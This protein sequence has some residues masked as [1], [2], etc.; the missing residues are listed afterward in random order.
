MF[1]T[2]LLTSQVVLIQSLQPKGREF[3]SGDFTFYNLWEP[4]KDNDAIQCLK[5][6]MYSAFNLWSAEVSHMLIRIIIKLITQVH[7]HIFFHTVL[8]VMLVL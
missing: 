2:V 4:C 3:E 8:L 1:C 6:Y 7:E 5:Y